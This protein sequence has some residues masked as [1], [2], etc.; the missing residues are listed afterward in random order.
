MRVN[1]EEIKAAIRQKNL[2]SWRRLEILDENTLGS[3]PTL[4]YS[5]VLYDW[6]GAH[7]CR[8]AAIVITNS[9]QAGVLQKYIKCNDPTFSNLDDAMTWIK[10]R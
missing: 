2:P 3:I 9:V 10:D 7:G 5:R 1:S 6:Y 8:A 4:E